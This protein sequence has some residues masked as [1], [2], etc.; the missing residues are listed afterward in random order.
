MRQAGDYSRAAQGVTRAQQLTVSADS[1]T[2]SEHL[3][4]IRR[5]ERVD[6]MFDPRRFFAFGPHDGHNI[7]PCPMF[8]QTLL[9]Q[10]GES[11]LRQ[12][13]LLLTGDGFRG[14]AMLV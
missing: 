5:V 7:K 8:K 12:I 13:L 10:P 11:G 4:E 6:E 3:A 1:A 14:M 9:F 2:A